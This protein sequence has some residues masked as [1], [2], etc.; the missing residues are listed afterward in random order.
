MDGT[1][2]GRGCMFEMSPASEK[3]EGNTGPRVTRS[4][5]VAFKLVRI[6]SSNHICLRMFSLFWSIRFFESCFQF[7]GRKRGLISELLR[8]QRQ[9]AEPSCSWGPTLGDIRVAP[10]VPHTHPYC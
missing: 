10:G 1:H 3:P 2:R 4:Y 8:D 9:P 6:H 5:S 7:P